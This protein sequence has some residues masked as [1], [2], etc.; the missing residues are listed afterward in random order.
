MATF[1]CKENGLMP[2]HSP[3]AMPARPRKFAGILLTL[4]LLAALLLPV[5]PAAAKEQ[6]LSAFVRQG[7]DLWRVPGMA[8]T[9]VNSEEV[10]Y[11]ESFGMTAIESGAPID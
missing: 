8:V 2:A 3:S 6:D 4:L 1:V 10:L 7:M 9:V 5:I 11:R